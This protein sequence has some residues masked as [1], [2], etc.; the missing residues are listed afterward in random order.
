[1]SWGDPNEAVRKWVADAERQEAERRA[2]K[3]DLRRSE[4]HDTVAHLRADMQHEIANL[5][6][7]MQHQREFLLNAVGQALGEIS[8]KMCDRAEA[9]IAKLENEIARKF[10]ETMGRLDAL[11]PDVRS[12]SKRYEFANERGDEQKA[13]IDLP[14]PLTPVIRKTTLN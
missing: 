12:R 10:G 14:N 3:R 4:E 7:E 8:N 6:A 11:A 1:M 13:I 2:A 9:S 5:R